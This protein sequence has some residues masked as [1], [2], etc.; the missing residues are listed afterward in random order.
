MEPDPPV[1]NFLQ[2]S[3]AVLDEER[4]REE[5]EEER[6]RDD[7]DLL[8]VDAG[9]GSR[10]RESAKREGLRDQ[11]GEEEQSGLARVRQGERA[12]LAS[13]YGF[14]GFRQVSRFSSSPLICGTGPICACY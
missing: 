3:S 7:G 2:W 10:G 13:E 9:V 14:F 8:A 6:Q 11:E 4:P 12:A 1:Y 5:E